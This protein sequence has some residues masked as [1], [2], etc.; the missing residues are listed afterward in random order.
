QGDRTEP[1]AGGGL[2]ESA[3]SRLRSDLE[4]SRG[5]GSNDGDGAAA[6]GGAGPG[7]LRGRLRGCDQAA[8]RCAGRAGRPPGHQPAKD[9]RRPR[10]QVPATDDGGKQGDGN[11]RG[12][13][14]PGAEHR[15]F[16]PALRNPRG[17]DPEG[18]NRGDVP[19]EQPTKVDVFITLVSA[20]ALGL[21][22]PQSLL[23]RADQVI[24]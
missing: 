1:F 10:A 11:C 6:S 2:L 19:M 14:V 12:A 9:V 21:T 8:G 23:Q 17:Q 3:Q 20:K 15:R 16:I 24:E 7:G 18:A 4:G 13:A 5:G 22:I